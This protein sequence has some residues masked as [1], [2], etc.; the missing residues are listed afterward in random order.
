MRVFHLIPL[1]TL[2]GKI[3]Y[4]HF[5][6]EEAQNVEQLVGDHRESVAVGI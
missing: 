2:Q 1:T 4:L 3:Y 6:N 5:I